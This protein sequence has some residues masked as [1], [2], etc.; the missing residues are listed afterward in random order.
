MLELPPL[1][2][3]IHYPWCVKKCPYCDF[4]SH[5]IQ[6]NNQTKQ[7]ID[8]LIKDLEQEK[9][10][11]QNRTIISIFFGG[12]TP[13]LMSYKNLDK[14]LN[15][16]TTNFKLADNIE[17]TIE[18]NPIIKNNNLLDF[19]KLGINRLSIG[20]QSFQDKYLKKLGR[21]HNNKQ[22]KE[23]IKSAYKYGFKNINIDLMYG[24]PEQSLKDLKNDINEAIIFNTE[25]ISYYE[26]TI[27]PNTYFAKYPPIRPCVDTLFDMSKNITN[28]LSLA[29]YNRYE[30][31]AYSRDRK[32]QHNINYWTF[33]D[34]IGIGAGAH[35]KITDVDNYIIFRTSKV[36]VPKNYMN[37]AS[38]GRKIN[39]INNISFEFML[40]VLRLKEKTPIELF[41]KR[42]GQSFN[43][44]KNIINKITQKSLLE[45]SDKYI[46]TTTLG[47]N[48]LH[49]IQELFL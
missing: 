39:K 38:N 5:N 25:H 45:K 31:S 21:L 36:R 46:K 4:N 40:N 48:N 33:G 1:S 3:Y 32:C 35:G 24:L 19:Y 8:C 22:A 17:I 42:T 34:Y 13:S 29:G 37:L 27:E 26:L 23:T 11:T 41:E 28:T 49:N 20:V 6:D 10:W 44:I 14:I 7:Y 30:V 16:I 2:L 15:Y 9:I 47:F 12:G 18:V 43:S